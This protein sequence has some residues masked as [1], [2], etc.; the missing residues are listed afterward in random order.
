MRSRSR[1]LSSIESPSTKTSS[2]S[3]ANESD[4]EAKVEAVLAKRI[5]PAAKR[6]R[7]SRFGPANAGSP[8]T[9]NMQGKYA[10]IKERRVINYNSVQRP[11][12]AAFNGNTVPP[13]RGSVNKTADAVVVAASKKLTAANARKEKENYVGRG[14]FW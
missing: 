12:A 14:A 6:R 10:E 13:R 11:S 8:D 1:S 5:S 3:P 4:A 2:T 7:V 9:N